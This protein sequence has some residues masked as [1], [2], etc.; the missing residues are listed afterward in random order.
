MDSDLIRLVMCW[1]AGLHQ[2]MH[3]LRR[4]FGP[5]LRI[6]ARRLCRRDPQLASHFTPEA[7]VREVERVLP[8]VLY[9]HLPLLA[10]EA[11][12]SFRLRSAAWRLVVEEST[13]ALRRR[14]LPLWRQFIRAH[15]ARVRGYVSYVLGVLP[16]AAQDMGLVQREIWRRVIREVPLADILTDGDMTRTLLDRIT[17]DVCYNRLREIL[18]PRVRRC[19]SGLL[20]R[21]GARGDG[22][23]GEDS[24][25]EFNTRLWEWMP[26]SPSEIDR[27]QPK[28]LWW[29]PMARYSAI[30]TIRFIEGRR[31]PSRLVDCA[32]TSG[33]EGVPVPRGRRR[34]QGAKP[35]DQCED[36]R[37]QAR[38]NELDTKDSIKYL[39]NRV[40]PRERKIL[41]L[42]FLQDLPASEVAEVV[43]C[44][45]STVSRIIE[46]VRLR[47][48]MNGSAESF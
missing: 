17:V 38:L 42:R 23:G 3:L 18:E 26:K 12:D 4:E 34:A 7:I 11:G 27:N 8:R 36:P 25:Q 48:G 15:R 14:L 28:P 20:C 40:S 41:D 35:V 16:G 39:L 6:W 46:G 45:V 44:S 47:F 37:W 9:K 5:L 21:C 31:R 13:R 33:E 19:I 2:A 30:D 43:G 24:L 29:W 22:L 1:A 32:D 10:K